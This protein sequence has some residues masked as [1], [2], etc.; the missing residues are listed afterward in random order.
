[1]SK[2]Q[3]KKH[4]D[5]LKVFLAEK[6]AKEGGG[7]TEEKKEEAPSKKKE[8]I[9]FFKKSGIFFKFC[10]NPFKKTNKIMTEI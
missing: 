1:M 6:A 8:F 9:S 3:L 10:L 7:A 4:K 2:G 5:K